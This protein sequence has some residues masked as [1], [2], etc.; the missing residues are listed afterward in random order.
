MKI[1]AEIIP[2]PAIQVAIGGECK[3]MAIARSDLRRD[4]AY[5]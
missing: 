1:L 4:R 5:D 3:R 2:A